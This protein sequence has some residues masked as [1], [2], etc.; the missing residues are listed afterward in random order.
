MTQQCFST[1]P[2]S[3]RRAARNESTVGL[4][5][6]CYF[7]I[8]ITILRSE[9]QLRFSCGSGFFETQCTYTQTGWLKEKSFMTLKPI[10]TQTLSHDLSYS[11]RETVS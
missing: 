4:D 2:G 7:V 8:N 3:W 10:A 1:G 5:S 9:Y 6:N 11:G